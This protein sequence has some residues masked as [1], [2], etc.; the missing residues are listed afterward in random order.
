MSG[1]ENTVI[2][3]LLV[4]ALAFAM[5]A[6]AAAPTQFFIDGSTSYEQ[7]RIVRLEH[8]L[9]FSREP[10]VSIW[11]VTI[12]DEKVFN[13]YV[14]SHNLPT[15]SGYTFLGLNHTHLNEAYLLWHS[16]RD[17]LFLLGH[18]SGHL[19]CSCRSE[20]KANEIAHML[21]GY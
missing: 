3:K 11:E 21:V 4:L 9:N 19:I 17:V 14:Q 2:K 20:Q 12:D 10:M 5:S 1:R 8:S 7:Q 18:E 15:E 6:V 16:D 13:D